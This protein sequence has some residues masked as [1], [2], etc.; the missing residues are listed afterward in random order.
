LDSFGRSGIVLVS[1]AIICFF[2]EQSFLDSLGRSGIVLMSVT[3]IIFVGQVIE[4]LVSGCN[5]PEKPDLLR[6]LF[7]ADF[8]LFSIG[9]VHF[10]NLGAIVF[11]GE[12]SLE[13][14]DVGK[15][16]VAQVAHV[17]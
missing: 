6:E 15:L 14:R 3:S 16:L 12:M 9:N 8:A 17:R 13:M 2:F 5:V 10:F 1:V 4:D 11:E 7:G